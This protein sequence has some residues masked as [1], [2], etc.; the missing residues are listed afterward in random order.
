MIITNA[1][2]K[3]LY[4]SFNKK[5]FGNS[6]PKELP[7]VFQM[8]DSQRMMGRTIIYRGR[9]PMYIEIAVRYKGNL[10]LVAMTLLHE[11]LHVKY[12]K[13]DH[14]PKFHREMLRL[15]KAGA[16]KPYW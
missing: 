1:E 15:A 4:D 13:M 8:L 12:P 11:M 14:G 6:L 2:L 7:V 16:F 10:S 9:H 5:Y 3:R